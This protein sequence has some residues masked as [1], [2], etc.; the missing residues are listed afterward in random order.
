MFSRDV[1]CCAVISRCFRPL[2]VSSSSSSSSSSFFSFSSKKLLLWSVAVNGAREKHRASDVWPACVICKLFGYRAKREGGM[3]SKLW[4]MIGAV[5][6]Y[7]LFFVFLK[8]KKKKEKGNFFP[9][10][11]VVDSLSSSSSSSGRGFSA[12]RCGKWRH[13]QQGRTDGPLEL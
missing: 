1:Y 5:V 11:V 4:R 10:P 6:F 2:K 13:H 9:F 8:K 3:L 7:F 12:R